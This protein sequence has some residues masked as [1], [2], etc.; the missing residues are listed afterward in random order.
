M[1]VKP[2]PPIAGLIL[3]GQ[4]LDSRFQMLS[5]MDAVYTGLDVILIGRERRRGSSRHSCAIVINHPINNRS[6]NLPGAT[7]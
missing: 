4:A 7:W 1:K 5:H 2:R 3:V 6:L